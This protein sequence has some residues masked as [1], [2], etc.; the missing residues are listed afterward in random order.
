M[1]TYGGTFP[2]PTIRRPTGA[3]TGVTFNNNLPLSAGPISIHNHGNHSAPEHDGSPHQFL[4]PRGDSRTYI[5][6][7]VED[8]ASERGA[9]QFYHDH[10]MD[11]TG[12]NVWNGLAGFYILDDP[13]DPPSL[14]A[15]SFDI[16]LMIVDRQFDANNQIPYVFNTNG[17]TGNTFLVNG[18]FEPHLDV[19]DR[20][21]RFRL[22][23]NANARSLLLTIGD[24]QLA[25]KQVQQIGTE[26]GL[27]PAP[28][29][30]SGMLATPAE[31]LDI[32]VDFAGL[33]GQT[34]YLFDGISGQRLL[35]FRVTQDIVDD[36]T[37][38]AFLRPLPDLGE[39]TN[40]RT[41]TFGSGGGKWLING[42]AFD[43][44]RVDAQPLLG[45]TETWTF[46]N[47]SGAPHVVHVHDVDQ[48]CVSRSNGPCQAYEL[49]KESW[50][51]G[52][53]QSVTVKLKFSDHVG[54][55]MI[56]CHIL[57]HEDDGMM[58]TFEVVTGEAT[59]TPT[60]PVITETPTPPAT[61]TAVP[62]ATD[63]PP[64][65]TPTSTPTAN[66]D[67]IDGD[68]VPNGIDNCPSVANPDQINTDFDPLPGA[69][70]SSPPEANPP[71]NDVTRP[72]GDGAGDAC[73]D[74]DDN[75]GLPDVAELALGMP[76]PPGFC[77]TAS[78]STN[79][80]LQDSDG[81][82]II[83]GAECA[84]GSDP[85]NPDSRPPSCAALSQPDTDG[86]RLC[87]AFEIAI[88]SDPF[89]ADTDGDGINDGIEYRGYGSSPLLVDTDGDGCS[90][91][92]EIASVDTNRTVNSIDLLIV[93]LQFGRSDRPVQDV[94]KNGVVNS[95]DLLLVALQFGAFC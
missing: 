73:D 25:P 52:S 65:N 95:N 55:Y 92:L 62:T 88:G 27:L 16:P 5:Y 31:R 69:P 11:V 60:A 17:V 74:D 47:T 2:G 84:L 13:A 83:D 79:P 53:G 32:V 37:V 19:G 35:E 51:I 94:D 46:T 78:Q 57:E 59:P 21:Y 56:H 33:L 66:P 54:E 8:G 68:G 76:S 93:A 48:Q 15:G 38:P 45:S 85:A 61:A 42:L 86:D 26:S 20:K 12:R 81:D 36:S 82:V 29:T 23:N 4:V 30:R 39:P 50:F 1:W 80:L 43:H 14:P 41:F 9:T 70:A 75:D 3:T 7:H 28:V 87:D 10:V 90:D 49:Q 72:T 18:V 64:I 71:P 6:E 44:N 34:L 91:G 67:D 63:T 58:S 89:L 22:L 24:A 40:S 77:P